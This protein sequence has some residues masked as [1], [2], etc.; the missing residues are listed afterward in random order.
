M[1]LFNPAYPSKCSSH[2]K[3]HTHMLWETLV[4]MFLL[5]LSHSF[6]QSD[7]YFCQ[8]MELLSLLLLSVLNLSLL[9]H[10]ERA[11]PFFWIFCSK[12][13]QDA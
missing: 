7:F 4:L 3:K 8:I 5:F 1:R 2:G 13:E 6:S 12:P 9:F 11:L 10:A